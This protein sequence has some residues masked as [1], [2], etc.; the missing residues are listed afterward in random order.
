[1]PASNTHAW[2]YKYYIQASILVVGG[3]NILLPHM[4]KNS[5]KKIHMSC[6]DISKKYIYILYMYYKPFLFSGHSLSFPFSI[7]GGTYKS[8]AEMPLL[9]GFQRFDD[10]LFRFNTFS[11]V[12]HPSYFFSF[13]RFFLA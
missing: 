10:L 1:M 2:T 4:S 8:I 9:S 3:G 5:S 11:F 6:H 12:L 13:V 7:K